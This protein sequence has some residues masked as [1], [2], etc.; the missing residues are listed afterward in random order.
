MKWVTKSGPSLNGGHRH[1]RDCPVECEV[2]AGASDAEGCGM[3]ARGSFVVCATRNE[4]V[5]GVVG[6]V[7]DV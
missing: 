4:P 7:G 3:D 5:P 6:I 1:G 2:Q